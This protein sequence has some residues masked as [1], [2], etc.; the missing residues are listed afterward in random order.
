MR[1]MKRLLVGVL[2]GV[3]LASPV[4]AAED[5]ACLQNNRIWGWQAV[6]DRTLIITDRSYER[7]T[8]NLR[9][10]CVGLGNH[11]GVKLMV[12]TKTALGCL[13]AGDMV[14]FESAGLG[15]LSCF[16]SGV[17]AGVPA[18]QPGPDTN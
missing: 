18:A 3:N 13:S 17:R 4:L 12:R 15:P 9:G 16:I 11:A 6:N 5:K 7:Y 10:G 14:A 8:V 2:M 1:S